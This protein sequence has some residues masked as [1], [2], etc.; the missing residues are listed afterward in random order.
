MGISDVEEIVL[1]KGIK[2]F[3]AMLAMIVLFMGQQ[4][5]AVVV[6][7]LYQASVPITNQSTK[8]R[9]DAIRK[10][11]GFVLVKA[12]G[13]DAVTSIPSIW[14]NVNNISNYVQQYTYIENKNSA[15]DKK[16]AQSCRET[17]SIIWLWGSIGRAVLC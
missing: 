14:D 12:S 7:N 10:A 8:A 2:C 1:H 13:N 15:T 3:I 5:Y 4:A 9:N 6:N 11:L 17:T 16:A